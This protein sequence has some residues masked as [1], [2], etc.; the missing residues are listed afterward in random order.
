MGRPVKRDIV[1]KILMNKSVL[2]KQMKFNFR[3]KNTKHKK[4]FKSLVIVFAET[5]TIHTILNTNCVPMS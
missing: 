3:I 1:T 4:S 5:A 2:V